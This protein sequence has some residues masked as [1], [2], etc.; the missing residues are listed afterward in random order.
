MKLLGLF[1]HFLVTVA[2]SQIQRIG[3]NIIEVRVNSGRCTADTDCHQTVLM[4]EK[5]N[6]KT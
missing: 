1:T 5:Y 6:Y 4:T 2:V 3:L